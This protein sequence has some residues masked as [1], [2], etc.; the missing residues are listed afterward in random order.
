MK[1]SRATLDDLQELSELFDAYRQF[2][3]Q[4][5]DVEGSKEFLRARIE[6]DEAM[7]FLCRNEEAISVGFTL[8]YPS[9][10][11]VGRKRIFVLNDLYVDKI[12]RNKGVATSLLQAAADFARGNGAIRLHLETEKTNRAAQALYEREG[13]IKEDEVFHYNYT[14]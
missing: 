6:K 11:S 2:Y 5:S 4:E 8:L 1:I 10:T 14:L 13:W 3:R 7:I 9:F 12:A